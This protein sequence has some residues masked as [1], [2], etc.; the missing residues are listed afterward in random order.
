MQKVSNKLS[1]YLLLLSIVSS[2][3][4]WLLGTFRKIPGFFYFQGN[5][6]MLVIMALIILL[7]LKKWRLPDFIIIGLVL[8][9]GVFNFLTSGVKYTQ[10]P[11]LNLVIPLI[12]MVI[13][14]YRLCSFDKLEKIFL[15]LIQVGVVILT[16]LRLVIALPKVL[17]LS[18]IL[19]FDNSLTSLWIN[20]NAI[21]ASLLIATMLGSILIKQYGNRML[22]ITVIPLYALGL[23]GTWACQS[24]TS[25]SVLAL[26]IILDNLLPKFIFQKWKFWILSF[27]AYF[28]AIPFV[29]FYLAD[30]ADLELFTGREDIWKAFFDVWLSKNNFVQTGL[31]V[32]VHH[33][34]KGDLSTH[35]SYLYTLSN[36]GVIGYIILF[37]T[38]TILLLSLLKKSVHLSKTQVSLL[39]AFGI[40]CIYGTMED[41]FLVATWMP[42]IYSFLGLAL[43]DAANLLADKALPT[44]KTTTLQSGASRMTRLH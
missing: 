23:A 20:V 34:S 1:Q 12:I 43:H 14:C 30:S 42:L 28:I 5:K 9:T 17:S 24:K 19:A 10:T 40:L 13:E 21:G 41:T 11:E 6:L 4:V 31:G 2:Y 22:N 38:I 35:S 8:L 3:S 7:N 37:G 18:E 15:L 16:A 39:L 27:V 32:F 26:F 33:T 44:E 36:Y 29:S 25:F